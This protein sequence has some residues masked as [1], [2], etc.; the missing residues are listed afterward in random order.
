[1]MFTHMG[2]LGYANKE[3]GL[4]KIIFSSEKVVWT[5]KSF[6][7]DKMKKYVRKGNCFINFI[8]ILCVW[9]MKLNFNFAVYLF[10]L[11]ISD[12]LH[13]DKRLVILLLCILFA[14]FCN[15]RHWLWFIKMQSHLSL[16][17]QIILVFRCF[18]ESFYSHMQYNA[19]IFHPLIFLHINC[20]IFALVITC[21]MFPQIIFCSYFLSLSFLVLPQLLLIV[22]MIL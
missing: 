22:H 11:A 21:T 18:V 10:L 1:M 13:N 15:L 19:A 20:I 2:C 9:I 8:E 12:M 4:E 14:S 16:F 7:T 3:N 5:Q 17:F 6:T